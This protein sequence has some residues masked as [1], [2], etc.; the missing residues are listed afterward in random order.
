MLKKL[1]TTM[2]V[3]II[4]FAMGQASHVPIAQAQFS[5]TAANVIPLAQCNE[6]VALLKKT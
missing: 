1:T 3:T 5:C 6:L 2:V 4:L